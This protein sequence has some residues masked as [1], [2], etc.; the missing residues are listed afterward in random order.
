MDPIA[1]MFSQIQNAIMAGKRRIEL[2]GSRLKLA[3]LEILK[4]EG[5][6]ENFEFIVQQNKSAIKIIIGRQRPT[7]R[8]IKISKPSLKVYTQAKHIKKFNRQS[9]TLIISTSQGI[10]TDHEAINRGL[11]GEILGRIEL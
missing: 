6:V 9:Q 7:S 5:L 3:I 11:G 10:M 1:Q 4:K 8:I 2:P